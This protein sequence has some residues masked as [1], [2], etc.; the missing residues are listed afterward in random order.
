MLTRGSK[1]VLSALKLPC[2]DVDRKEL[3]ASR[4]SEADFW[5]G[6]S[7]LRTS[8]VVMEMSSGLV[9]KLTVGNVVE[10]LVCRPV[11]EAARDLISLE[12]CL[13]ATRSR[14]IVGTIDLSSQR[15]KGWG[16]KPDQGNL[17]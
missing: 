4:E 17:L 7:A 16:I 12:V 2:F 8:V 3:V 5:T 1:S 14:I 15:E 6:K 11:E 13:N 9:R 10:P